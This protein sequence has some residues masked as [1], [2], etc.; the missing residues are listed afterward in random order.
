MAS[1]PNNC[2]NISKVSENVFPNLTQNFTQ[3]HCQFLIAENFTEQEIHAF[4]LNRHST[5][6]KQTRMIRFMAL[7]Q[8]RS[9]LRNTTG[10]SSPTFALVH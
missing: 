2:F 1:S 4:T 9:L 5:M 6:T 3:T 10:R 7:A 8:G